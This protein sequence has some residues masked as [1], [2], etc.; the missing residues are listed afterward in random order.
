MAFSGPEHGHAPRRSRRGGGS[1]GGAQGSVPGQS[2]TARGRPRH[3]WFA[4]RLFILLGPRGC[5]FTESSA[6]AEFF[7]DVAFGG[8]RVPISWQEHFAANASVTF[9]VQTG[10]DGFLGIPSP[11]LGCH[12]WLSCSV[13]ASCLRRTVLDSSGSGYASVLCALLCSTV[14]TVHVSVFGGFWLL[15]HTLLREGG[16]RILRS[17]LG[18]TKDFFFEP[19]VFGSH[20]SGVFAA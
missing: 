5:G 4:G 20:C 7:R 14:D 8:F 17:I 12:F 15:F 16:P 10:P 18:Q 3:R 13:S 6:E 1:V 9:S 2:S 19:P 11:L